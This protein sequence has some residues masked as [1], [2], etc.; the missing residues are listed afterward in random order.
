MGDLSHNPEKRKLWFFCSACDVCSPIFFNFGN[1]GDMG[2]WGVIFWGGWVWRIACCFSFIQG[3]SNAYHL[4]PYQALNKPL[5]T[6]PPP[7]NPGQITLPDFQ[8]TPGNTPFFL[9]M[10][11]LAYPWLSK[12]IQTTCQTPPDL[13]DPPSRRNH[14]ICL[15]TKV[16]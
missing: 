14:E 3:L 6:Q 4:S 9:K 11:I 10:I 8:W 16:G 13:P 2:S 1:F 12:L 7:Q 15:T 5:A